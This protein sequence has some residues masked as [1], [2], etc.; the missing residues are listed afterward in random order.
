MG[1]Q[2]KNLESLILGWPESSDSSVKMVW[3]SPN[4]LFGQLSTFP[5]YGRLTRAWENSKGKSWA[6][7][8]GLIEGRL[9]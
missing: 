6:A 2:E 4:V 1:M 3:K 8:L 5:S 9:L 7:F